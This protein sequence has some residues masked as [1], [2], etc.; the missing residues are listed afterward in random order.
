LCGVNIASIGSSHDAL[1]APST[2]EW[3]D[4]FRPK[5]IA[6]S[7]ES[8]VAILNLFTHGD[9][10]SDAE[11]MDE[12]LL[13]VAI[14]HDRMHHTDRRLTGVK[15][16]A[17]VEGQPFS[18]GCCSFV[19]TIEPNNGSYWSGLFNRNLAYA[20]NELFAGPNF[21]DFTI[22]TRLE[23]TNETASTCDLTTLNAQSVNQILALL[24]WD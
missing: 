14:E 6:N 15:V 9:V 16:K 10:K 20:T 12:I 2:D 1:L 18:P 5:P 22:G 8:Y 3:L 17:D 24:E 13:L 19:Y 11:A 23:D 4:G 21:F 7:G